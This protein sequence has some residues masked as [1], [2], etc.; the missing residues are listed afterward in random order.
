MHIMHIKCAD[1]TPSVFC[2]KAVSY[3]FEC[4]LIFRLKNYN[5]KLCNVHP[6]EQEIT[7]LYGSSLI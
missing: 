7:Q 4:C 6:K 1:P 2:V 5:S 3:T